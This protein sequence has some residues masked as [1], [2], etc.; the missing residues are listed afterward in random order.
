MRTEES[1]GYHAGTSGAALVSNDDPLPGTAT[2]DFINI[3]TPGVVL[4]STGGPGTAA[5]H[6]AG[7]LLTLAAL[8]LLLRRRWRK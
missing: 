8:T 5:Y 7:A 2:V 1:T 3:Y 6:L 4:P